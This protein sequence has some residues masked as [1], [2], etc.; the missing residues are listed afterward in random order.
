M[1]G[2]LLFRENINMSS[3]TWWGPEH[4]V[5]LLCLACLPCCWQHTCIGLLYIESLGCFC[6]DVIGRNL[7][8]NVPWGS[9]GFLPLPQTQAGWWASWFLLDWTASLAG[10]CGKSAKGTG[11]QLPMGVWCLLVDWTENHEDWSRGRKSQ[12]TKY[13][14]VTWH[15]TKEWLQRDLQESGNMYSKDKTALPMVS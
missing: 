7:L 12:Q 3:Q 8:K 14:A 1:W 11:L 10:S 6:G 5:T 2:H 13:I 15:K 4:R 9:C